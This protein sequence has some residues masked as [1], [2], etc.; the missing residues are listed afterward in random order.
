M[1][2]KKD[3]SKYQII[4]VGAGISGLVLAERYSSLGKKVLVIEKRDHIGGNCYDHFD[5]E[6]ILIS[7]YGAHLFH[8][9]YEK[10]W[11]YVSKFTSWNSYEHKVLA[12]V[13]DKL[14]PVPVNIT[15]INKLFNLNI[16]NSKEMKIW[17]EE[18]QIKFDNPKN[19]EEVALSRVGKVLYNKIFK[20]YTIKQWNK[21]PSELD[22]S[23][24]A[25]IP[26]RDNFDDRYFS[27]K[28]QAQPEKGFTVL[29]E[30][31]VKNEFIDVFLKTDFFNIRDM[32]KD[33]EK[34]FYSGPI[35]QFFNYEFSDQRLEYRSLKFKFETHDKDFFQEGPVINYPNEH[36]FT[37]IVEYKHITKQDHFKTTISK[38]FP[39][40]IGDPYYP[41]LT[42]KNRNIY[43]KYLIKG[44]KLDNVF[45][46]GRLAEY[47]YINMD[48]AFNNALGLFN[49]LEKE[50]F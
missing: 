46:I 30:N 13:D 35:D 9:N 18:N 6:G 14:V 21:H 40:D 26:V 37:R 12:C 25:R 22:S 7:Q 34:L 49:K 10:V 32:I 16:K 3:F 17:L 45:F 43:K 5:K 27:D 15:T 31:M 48:E 38:E 29:F 11:N 2:Q 39:T 47:R 41:V 42:H 19:S 24:L 23:V 8:T 1:K 4:I 44:K 36:E 20:N 50:E 28:Y 33:Y